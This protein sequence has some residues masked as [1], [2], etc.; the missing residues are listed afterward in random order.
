MLQS[1]FQAKYW[2]EGGQKERKNDLNQTTE[3]DQNFP[4]SFK[5]KYL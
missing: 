3:C 1:R 2:K 5:R 4:G